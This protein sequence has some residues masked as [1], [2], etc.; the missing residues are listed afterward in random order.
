[1]AEKNA[2]LI[3][4][5]D[6]ALK[7]KAEAEAAAKAKADADKDGDADGDADKGGEAEA[8]DAASPKGVFVKNGEFGQG[9]L[10]FSGNG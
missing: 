10:D 1:M 5:S 4:Y 6:L 9:E 7:H 8:K 2:E 3:A